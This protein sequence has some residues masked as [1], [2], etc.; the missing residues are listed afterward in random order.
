MGTR[1]ELLENDW[2]R[3]LAANS[4]TT[5]RLWLERSGKVVVARHAACLV[6]AVVD[7]RNT[8]DLADGYLGRE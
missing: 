2:R 8:V 4:Q 5:A 7:G 1:Q 3:V 6:E